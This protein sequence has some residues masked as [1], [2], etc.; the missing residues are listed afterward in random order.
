MKQNS[1]FTLFTFGIVL[2]LFTSCISITHVSGSD[3]SPGQPGKSGDSRNVKTKGNGIITTQNRSITGQF[4][5][6]EVSSGIEVVVFQQET[7]LVEVQTD[8]NIQGIIT[9]KVENATLIISANG[10]YNTTNKPLVR[11]HV[12]TISGLKSSSGSEIESGTTLKSKSLSV[13]TSSGSAITLELEVDS[14]N[15]ESSSGSDL[16]VAGKALKVETSSSSGSTIDAGKLIANEVV[17]QTSSGS[18]TIVY[19]VNNFI[20][21][22]SS[23]GEIKYRNIPKKMDKS[24]SSGGTIT[25]N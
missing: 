21:K 7:P 16:K 5:K 20:G 10:M 15:L 8:E 2:F 9:T 3:G 23:G 14:I 17:S 22:A 25:S 12:P 13:V 24:E 4:D 18:T 19:P 6:I 11:V 1:V